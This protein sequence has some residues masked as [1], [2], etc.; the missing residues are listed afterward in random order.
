[1]PFSRRSRPRR[2]P[3]RS[4]PPRMRSGR[5]SATRNGPRPNRPPPF[6]MPFSPMRRRSPWPRPRPKRSSRSRPRGARR[7]CR[8][9]PSA[10]RTWPRFSPPSETWATRPRERTSRSW[11]CS[12]R[13]MKADR[14]QVPSRSRTPSVLSIRPCG[15]PRPP[16]PG[17]SPR[18]P[19]RASSF[20]ATNSRHLRG[21]RSTPRRATSRASSFLRI[22]SASSRR[23]CLPSSPV[24]RR[25]MRPW[26][27]RTRERSREST[28]SSTRPKPAWAKRPS[29][30]RPRS[31]RR[32]SRTR[33]FSARSR[34]G[35]RWPGPM[36]L[37]R[38][39]R[40]PRRKSFPW[41][42]EQPKGRWTLSRASSTRCSSRRDGGPVPGGSGNG[43]ARGLPRHGRDACG[44]RARGD[45]VRVVHGPCAGRRRRCFRGRL[46]ASRRRRVDRS[47]RR[48]RFR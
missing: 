44:R 11:R 5:F 28:C 46:A 29:G 23:P 48:G 15:P 26:N 38:R 17:T 4:A 34:S 14:P 41:R 10:N 27:S 39:P 24:H 36:R 42:P 8:R 32:P 35:T 22:E 33:P 30:P 16:R 1:M 19:C 20:P 9:L 43:G 45:L 47:V 40:R 12:T 7:P 3:R 37:L 21:R 18:G 13:G 31:E 6:S 2:R 25:P